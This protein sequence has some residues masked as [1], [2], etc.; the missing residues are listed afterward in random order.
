MRAISDYFW[1]RTLWNFSL[2]LRSASFCSLAIF[3]RSS[4]LSFSNSSIFSFKTSIC[5]F[6]CC[7]TLMWFRTSA[8][9]FCSCSSYSFGGKSID[10]NVEDNP[11]SFN[12]SLPLFFPPFVE[13]RS[14]TASLSRPFGPL[15]LRPFS[16]A[17]YFVLAF[18]FP[19]SFSCIRISM[20]VLM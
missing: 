11:V 4:S 17:C 18:S 3:Y 16:F 6:S 14:A 5:S 2:S 20:L 10:L 7:S 15:L 8:S 13:L 9:Y 1:S 19:S 12:G